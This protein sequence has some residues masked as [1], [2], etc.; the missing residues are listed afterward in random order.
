MGGFHSNSY[1]CSLPCCKAGKHFKYLAYFICNKFNYLRYIYNFAGII[2][3]V[4]D[5]IKRYSINFYPELPPYRV[6][7]IGRILYTSIIDRTIFVLWRAVLVAVCRCNNLA[8]CKYHWRFKHN[9][10]SGCFFDPSQKLSGWTGLFSWL[11]S[12][13]F[14][15]MKLCFNTIDVLSSTGSM[16]EFDNIESL[17]KVLLDNGWTYLTALNTMLFSLLHWPCGTTILT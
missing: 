14:R 13:G 15:P 7:Q 16:I 3:I 17:R 6:P 10:S 11:L 5:H 8:I 9:K 4:Q 1:F 12:W 2:W